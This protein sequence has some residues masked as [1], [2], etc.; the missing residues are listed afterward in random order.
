MIHFPFLWVSI[1]LQYFPFF[2]SFSISPWT[3]SVRTCSALTNPSAE[4]CLEGRQKLSPCSSPKGCAA[5]EGLLVE[6]F[7]GSTTFSQIN[8]QQAMQEIRYAREA[9]DMW[10]LSEGRVLIP[11]TS[12][13]QTLK[14][15]RWIRMNWSATGMIV[16]LG[17]DI[18]IDRQCASQIAFCIKY[19]PVGP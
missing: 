1:T 18:P 9:C 14:C 10:K 13:I 4:D 12:G 15:K 16:A 5:Q 11:V 17:A 2:A 19:Q 8:L 6:C 3:A 7:H